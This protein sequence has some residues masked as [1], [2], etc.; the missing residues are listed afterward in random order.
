MLYRNK[1]KNDLNE[2]KW[3]GVGGKF[4]KDESPEE[5]MLREVYEETGIVPI[6]W[7]YKGLVTFVSDKWEGEYMHL[8]TA[9]AQTEDVISCDEGEL[10]W[11]E[12]DEIMSLNMWEGDRVFMPFLFEDRKHFLMTLRY[13]GVE[14]IEAVL[15]GNRLDIL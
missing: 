7:E 1:K 15:D 10:R 13:R 9:K 11:I 4:E 2:G 6:S 8:F 5:C 3:I 14:L 12:E